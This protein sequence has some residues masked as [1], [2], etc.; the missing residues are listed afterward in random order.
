[1]VVAVQ[2][3]FP[4]DEGLPAIDNLRAFG[5]LKRLT[6]MKNYA[7]G[8]MRLSLLV[9]M[10]AVVGF[11]AAPRAQGGMDGNWA[12]TFETPMGSLDASA[13]F[14][15]DGDAL[16]GTMESQ[17][18][19]TSFKGTVKGKTFEFV[20]N[21]S[22]PNGDMSIQM[23]GEVEGDTIKGTFDFGQGT[24]TWTGKRNN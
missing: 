24:G 4:L 16:S 2:G 6:R 14:K 11:V 8:Y 7:E 1:M 3:I 5:G 15:T 9:A 18:G 12:L 21:V 13:T 10:I 17:A 20:M 23:S 19:S 22:T